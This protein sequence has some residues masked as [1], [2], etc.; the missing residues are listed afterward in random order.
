MRNVGA[1]VTFEPG[2]RSHWHTHPVG[3][4]LIV[5]S[6]IGLTQEWG[7][8][9]QEVRPG[10]VI[11]CPVG[12]KH[13]H[14]AAPSSSMTHISIAEDKDGYGVDWLEEVTDDQYYGRK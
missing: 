11:I 6:G 5:T 3:Q 12:V 8:P 2:A 10:D 1:S 14:G 7:K 13:W 4:A 9:I